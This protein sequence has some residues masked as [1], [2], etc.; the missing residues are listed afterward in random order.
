MDTTTNIILM[1]EPESI[2]GEMSL[3]EITELC[4]VNIGCAEKDHVKAFDESCDFCASC[5][6]SVRTFMQEQVFACCSVIDW[7]RVKVRVPT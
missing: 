3:K 5:P 2:H 4:P 1:R 6:V 7:L